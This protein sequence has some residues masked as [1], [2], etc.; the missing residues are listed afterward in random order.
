MALDPMRRIRVSRLMV[1]SSSRLVS[2]LLT[3]LSTFMLMVSGE[4]TGKPNRGS[5]FRMSWCPPPGG[6]IGSVAV[7]RDPRRTI[8]CKVSA[9]GPITEP[10]LV[11]SSISTEIE[12]RTDCSM[13]AWFA[14]ASSLSWALLAIASRLEDNRS[15]NVVSC[16]EAWCRNLPIAFAPHDL[17]SSESFTTS[18]ETT[19]SWET[20][21]RAP[22]IG[23]CF[24]DRS[25]FP[26]PTWSPG[27]RVVM[28]TLKPPIPRPYVS[29]PPG[30]MHIRASPLTIRWRLLAISPCSSMVVPRGTVRTAASAASTTSLLRGSKENGG[31]LLR[32]AASRFSRR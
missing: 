3:C 13:G 21:R 7:A 32:C 1:C 11:S 5:G 10:S 26:R 2:T 27:P 29:S 6:F 28:S 24:L 30:L 31:T 14:N 17:R 19:W 16:R 4:E 20:A 12:L 25:R 22:A 9:A 15:R 23:A 8:F 18:M